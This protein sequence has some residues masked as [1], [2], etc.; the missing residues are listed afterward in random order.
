[1][2]FNNFT[3]LNFT[4]QLQGTTKTTV[5]TAHTTRTETLLNTYQKPTYFG[6]GRSILGRDKVRARHVHIAWAKKSSG[7][8]WFF[9]TWLNNS[10]EVCC[11]E[12]HYPF[13]IIIDCSKGY[14][15]T[16]QTPALNKVLGNMASTSW[17][18]SNDQCHIQGHQLKSVVRRD[19]QHNKLSML[20]KKH[21]PTEKINIRQNWIFTENFMNCQQG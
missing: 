3:L 2:E 7:L 20:F 19:S 8:D 14:T 18:L 1:M 12:E 13:R 4:S 5:L 10:I 11:L 17:F 21:I 16:C 9:V 15:L 6:S